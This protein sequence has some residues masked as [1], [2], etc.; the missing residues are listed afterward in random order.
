MV[1]KEV[2]GDGTEFIVDT[3]SY[4][5]PMERTEMGCNVVMFRDFANDTGETVLDVLEA[6]N[7]ICREVEVERVAV[8][9]FRMDQ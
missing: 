5:K 3:L 9:K 7:F 4:F 1:V 8:I 2:E 6:G